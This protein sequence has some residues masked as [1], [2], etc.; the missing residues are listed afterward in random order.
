MLR[1]DFL[2]ALQ[3]MGHI[4][5][6]NFDALQ[7]AANALVTQVHTDEAA[8]AAAAASVNDAQAKVDAITAT[9]T[10]A[11]IP[12]ATAEAATAEAAPIA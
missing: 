5:E 2:T 9:L 8:R 7:A 12:V 3:H 6:L 1:G 11:I 4:M 10:A